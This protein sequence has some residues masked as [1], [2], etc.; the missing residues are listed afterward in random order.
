MEE[1]PTK[2]KV[3]LD[4]G[5]IDFGFYLDLEKAFHTVNHQ[6]LL[7]KLSHCGICGVSNDWFKFYLSNHN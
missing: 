2:D 3:A 6:V 4:S 5:N 7:P 1:Q